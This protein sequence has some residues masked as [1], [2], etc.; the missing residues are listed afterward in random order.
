MADLPPTKE[1]LLAKDAEIQAELDKPEVIEKDEDEQLPPKPDDKSGDTPDS[2]GDRGDSDDNDDVPPAPDGG[3]LAPEDVPD[4]KV[5]EDT[6]QPPV[7][8]TEQTPEE[9]FA[10]SAREAQVL[11]QSKKQLEESI[12]KA[13]E[14][15]EPTEAQLVAEYG[16]LSLLSEFERKLATQNL[17]N[18]LINEEVKRIRNDQRQSQE[19]KEAR[20]KEVD[21]YSIHP[22]TLKQ[23]PRLEGKQEEF[24]KF[25]S[26]P[27][28]LNLDLE[29][30]TTIFLA[31]LPPPVKHKGA[32]METG[33]GG[34]KD[35][36]KPKSDK[37]SIEESAI[38]MKN[39]YPE[40]VRLLKANKISTDID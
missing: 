27:T 17:H 13:Y 2:D 4:S 20:D 24:R 15:P 28:R 26:K 7:T 11:A 31:N 12:D 19:K 32:M 25:A 6:D 1:E 29:D 23:F 8:K 5:T 36:I 30:L 33:T 22:D 38:L 10:A 21:A 14:M 40:Y 18:K 34:P 16:D 37:I 9:K 3:E 35:K 39:N